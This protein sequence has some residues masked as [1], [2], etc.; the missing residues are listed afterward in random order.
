M[1]QHNSYHRSHKSKRQNANLS[2]RYAI[3]HYQH[4]PKKIHQNNTP[5]HSSIISTNG[6][7]NRNQLVASN[8]LYMGNILLTTNRNRTIMIKGQLS[9]FYGSIDE[10]NNLVTKE[11]MEGI[12]VTPVSVIQEKEGM[13]GMLEKLTIYYYEE[14][15]IL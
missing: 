2:R 8:D 5:I 12:Q 9:I 1:P 11:Q 7:P 3:I 14:E 6:L 4:E 13:L 15:I 10:W